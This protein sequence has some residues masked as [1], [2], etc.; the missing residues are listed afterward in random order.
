MNALMLGVWVGVG[1]PVSDMLDEGEGVDVG[2]PVSDMLDEGEGEGVGIGV[3]V[4]DM[5]GE[6][7]GVGVRVGVADGSCVVEGVAEVPKR[8]QMA[9]VGMSACSAEQFVGPR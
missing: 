7:E 2:V 1:E 6:S 5:L 9:L 3:P 8:V 4:S